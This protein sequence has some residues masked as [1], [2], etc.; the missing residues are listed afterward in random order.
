MVTNKKN[1]SQTWFLKIQIK[2]QLQ[3]IKTT[4]QINTRFLVCA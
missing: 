1:T 3:Q 2:R 4:K